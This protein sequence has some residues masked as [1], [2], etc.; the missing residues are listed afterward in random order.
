VVG[1]PAG[2]KVCSI[3]VRF[4]AGQPGGGSLLSYSDGDYFLLKNLK[5]YKNTHNLWQQNITERKST[6]AFKQRS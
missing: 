4:S 5:I 6:T 3:P 2:R 1:T